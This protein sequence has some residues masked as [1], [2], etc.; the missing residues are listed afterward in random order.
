LSTQDESIS[1]RSDRNAALRD[2]T[3]AY[4]SRIIRL[5]TYLQAAASF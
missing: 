3:K 1:E 5:Y 2:R 4:A